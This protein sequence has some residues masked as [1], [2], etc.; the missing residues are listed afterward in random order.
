MNIRRDSYGLGANQL[1]HSILHTLVPLGPSGVT[2]GA[3]GRQH[4]APNVIMGYPTGTPFWKDGLYKLPG[5][6]RNGKD[7][8]I[9]DI[10]HAGRKG[11]G[12]AGG[13]VQFPTIGTGN[14]KPFSGGTT[15]TLDYFLNAFGNLLTWMV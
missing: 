11:D 1:E 3:D 6:G 8:I 4:R 10:G 9:P 2:P 14:V 15:I 13:K 12:K 5:T 7:L